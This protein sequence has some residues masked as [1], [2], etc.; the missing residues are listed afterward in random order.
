M[1]GQDGATGASRWGMAPPFRPDR[2]GDVFGGSAPIDICF[3][4]V[5][6]PDEFGT[7]RL[8]DTVAIHDPQARRWLLF[9]KPRRV[10]V[11]E[12][13]EQL[14]PALTAIEQGVNQQGLWAAGFISYEAA[15]AFDLA[16]RV[17]PD[18]G[19]P[20]LWF[21]L[22]DP[23]EFAA[24][25]PSPPAAPAQPPVWLPSIAETD[26][27]RALAQI[28][29]FIRQGET[30]QVNFTFRLRAKL[31]EEPWTLFRRLA[32]THAPA[33]GAYVAAG[34]W[35]V[36]SFSPE[37]FFS[38]D[39][40]ELICRPMKGTAE[41]G[42]TF[43]ADEQEGRALQSCPKNR[44][45]NLMIVDMTRNDLGKISEVGSV[46]VTDL[47]TVE[48]LPTL[49]QMTSTIRA[50]TKASWTGILRALF[51]AA[52]IT[53]APKPHT[54]RI[55][56]DLES[57]PR[58][59]YTGAIGY[60][61]PGRRAQFNVA[62]RTLVI[63]RPSGLAEYGVG[64]GITWDSTTQ[65]ERN[66]ALAKARLILEPWPEFELLE[67]MRWAPPAGYFLRDLHLDRLAR[68]AARFAFPFDRA[69]T[70]LELDV[71]A[72]RLP[73]GPHKVR[74]LLDREGAVSCS[75]GLLPDPPR[76]QPRRVC[77]ASA[78]ICASDLF[79]H[80]KT[81]HRQ[82]YESAL[83]AC[84]GYDDVILWNEQGELTESC[85]ANLVVEL[86][87]RLF[88]PPTQCGLLAGTYRHWMLQ[89]G[90]VSERV[91]RLDDL[92]Q[93]RH[94]FLVNSVRGQEEVFVDLPA[95]GSPKV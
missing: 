62:I 35:A 6:R 39:G 76:P 21:G 86:D 87:D 3:H 56:A 43:E 4:R 59:L 18:A 24:L 12:T 51:P 41:R 53:G 38:L 90:L 57:T 11:A 27:E 47:F 84:P 22:F 79:L 70:Q 94:V 93:A 73:C 95:G 20:L 80:H 92:R 77:L 65:A 88:T 36:A 30:Y 34:A 45:E 63:H 33:Y 17:R 40:Q 26:Y 28:K 71:L 13:I 49:W 83:V 32:W 29:E 1:F 89:E 37:L 5:A 25:E 81:T 67:T 48:K 75:A 50:Q 64:G 85:V 82:S 54:M 91:L 10:V 16:L 60:L 2:A 42:L 68:S 46:Q 14:I 7:D 78:P 8:R 23:P 74:L 19:F 66:E 15:P 61:A 55:I 52:S 44:A 58:R 9:R 69:A 31:P 72:A